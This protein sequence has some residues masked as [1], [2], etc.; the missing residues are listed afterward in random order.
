MRRVAVS[1]IGVVSPLGNSA[2]DVLANA[3]AG[4]SGIRRL[5]IPFASRLSAPIAGTAHFDEEAH[6]DEFD[7]QVDNIKRFGPNYLAL[8][9][10]T[11]APPDQPAGA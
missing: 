3:R 5:D 4:R 8:Q 9:S 2:E 11:A 6:F 10:F 7:K 1:G